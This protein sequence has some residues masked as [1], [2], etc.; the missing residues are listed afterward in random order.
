[1]STPSQTLCIRMINTCIKLNSNIAL[2]TANYHLDSCIILWHNQNNICVYIPNP[3]DNI[4]PLPGTL[5][6]KSI[7]FL[8]EPQSFMHCGPGGAWIENCQSNPT[9]ML[10]VEGVFM[11]DTNDPSLSQKPN[12]SLMLFTWYPNILFIIESFQKQDFKP[13]MLNEYDCNSHSQCQPF[14]PTSLTS[15]LTPPLYP[16]VFSL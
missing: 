16:A 7:P 12:L 9:Q 11:T 5:S 2:H 10:F 15:I 14:T 3:Q 4:G 6:K 13:E 8:G 1:M